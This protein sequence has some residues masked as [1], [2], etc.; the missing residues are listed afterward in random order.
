LAAAAS[1]NGLKNQE[2]SISGVTPP[3]DDFLKVLQLLRTL[4]DSGAVSMR[5]RQDAQKQQ[6]SILTLR[7]PSAG[8]STLADITELRRLLKLDPD[9]TEFTLVFGGMASHNRE[10]AIIT[11]SVLHILTTMAAQVEVPA[12]DLVEGRATPGLEASSSATRPA[13]LV[14]IHSSADKPADA[15]VAVP[16]RDVWFWIDDRDLRSKRA[17]AFML[18]LFTLADTS[19][20][21]SLPLI[22]IPAQ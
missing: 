4:Q 14:H 7:S 10:L 22:T 20:R 1:I 8:E 12:D 15:F 3:D 13:R 6:T 9:A 17:F 2:T 19:A 18:M 21:E 11:R 5:V 16:Y